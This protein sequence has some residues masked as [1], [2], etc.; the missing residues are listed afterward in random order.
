MLFLLFQ[1]WSLNLKISKLPLNNIEKI[2]N[3]NQN[4]EK[5]SLFVVKYHVKITQG[6]VSDKWKNS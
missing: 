6:E 4:N 2:R 3:G 5:K 1:S